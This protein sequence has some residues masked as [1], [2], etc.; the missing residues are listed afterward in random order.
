MSGE[1]SRR[2]CRAFASLPVVEVNGLLGTTLYAA[3]VMENTH[4]GGK[5][6][7]LLKSSC[8]PYLLICREMNVRN[9][10]SE[11][12]A[13][14]GTATVTVTPTTSPETAADVLTNQGVCRG[15]RGSMRQEMK[16]SMLLPWA[17]SVQTNRRGISLQT[18]WRNRGEKNK[19]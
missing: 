15:S 16:L 5:Q 12:A 8:T 11:D 19:K 1:I 4:R 14:L 2:R 17:A 13:T 18:R 10:V 3:D 6:K 7:G 9:E